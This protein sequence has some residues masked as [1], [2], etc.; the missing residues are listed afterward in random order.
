MNLYFDTSALVKFFH[1]EDGTDVVTNL[2][3]NEINTC[4]II[5][6][7]HL[8]LTS[9]VYRRYRNNEINDDQLAVVLAGLIKESLRFKTE[10]FN[11]LTVT[12]AM[13]LMK[14]FG[15]S[16]GLRTLDALHLASFKLI[17][18]H[19]WILVSSDKLMCSITEE[20][21]YSYINPGIP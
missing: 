7:A 17:A 1:D 3:L 13:E 12:E 10:P 8:E 20:L 15:K 21:G 14:Q 2:I 9:A 11:D 4:W 16:H 6:I 18:D 5:E 19:D